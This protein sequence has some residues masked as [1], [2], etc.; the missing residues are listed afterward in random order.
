MSRVLAQAGTLGLRLTPREVFANPTV[1]SLAEV[2]RTAGA[3]ARPEPE[4]REDVWAKILQTP[5]PEL[6]TR[7]GA[8]ERIRID[9][10]D[11]ATWTEH[12]PG[13]SG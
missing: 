13:A 1:A 9:L 5:D 6:G 12:L 7:S 3:P 11:A 4:D 2:V 10:P 8:T